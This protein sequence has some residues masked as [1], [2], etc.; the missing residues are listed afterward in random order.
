MAR[1]LQISSRDGKALYRKEQ[2]GCLSRKRVTNMKKRDEKQTVMQTEKL[3]NNKTTSIYTRVLEKASEVIAVATTDVG[4]LFRSRRVVDPDVDSGYS[5]TH[6]GQLKGNWNIVAPK[7]PKR[8]P[9]K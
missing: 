8:A 7:T 1:N 4:D 2:Y 5:T 6:L 3:E 9:A